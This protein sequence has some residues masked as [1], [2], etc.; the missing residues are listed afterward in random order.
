MTMEALGINF[1]L[2]LVQSI[3]PI[4]WF[5]FTGICLFDLGRKKLT[6]TPLALWVLI[7]CAIPILGGLAYCIIRPSA[8][9][10]V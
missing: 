7:I 5:V 6:G 8:E 10:R 4:V 1:G 3:I 2:L 9:S